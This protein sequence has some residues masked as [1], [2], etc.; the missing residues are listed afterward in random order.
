M[1]RCWY[2]ALRGDLVAWVILAWTAAVLIGSLAIPFAW[3]RYYLPLMLVYILLSAS[4]LGR[5]L[6]RRRERT[7]LAPPRLFPEWWG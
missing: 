4:G 3:Q 2:D 7:E 6:V 5:L 1:A